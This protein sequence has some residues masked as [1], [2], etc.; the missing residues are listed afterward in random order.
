MSQQTSQIPDRGERER[1]RL[2]SDFDVG[3]GLTA[4]QTSSTDHLTKTK[5][6]STDESDR[7]EDYISVYKLQQ[8]NLLM[9]LVLLSFT[10]IAL[11]GS[12]SK[13]LSP[14]IAY[15]IA[16]FSLFLAIAILTLWYQIER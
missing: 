8:V 7:I 2:Y 14:F 12:E 10:A 13:G 3:G 1:K 16:L 15:P 5:N 11:W 4:P 9:A 6:T